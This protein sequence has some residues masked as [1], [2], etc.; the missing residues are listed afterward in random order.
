[1]MHS[2]VNALSGVKRVRGADVQQSGL[3]SYVSLEERVPAN[4]PLRGVRALLNE[5]LETMHR[6]FE[7]VYAEGGR[8]SIPPERLVR[9]LIL[10]V[11]YSIR[12][13]RLLCEQ[14]DYNLLFRWFVG[15]SVDE[16]IWDHSTFT[17]N[18]ERLI[19]AKVARKLLR[20]VIR[21]A[22]AARLL[23]NEHFS[24]DGTLIESWAAVKSMRRRD[25]RDEPR[26]PGR[27]P[28][29]DFHGEKRTNE[30]HVSPSDPEAKLYRKGKGQAAKLYYM[31]HVLMEHRHGLPVDVEVTEANGFAERE[32]ALAMLDRLSR[33][34][35]RTLAADKAYDVAEFLADCR[36]RGV[37]PHVA[38]N[39]GRAGGSALDAR[40]TRH[41]GYRWSQRI[42]KR[43]EEGFGWG[44]DGRPLRKMKH[45]GHTQVSFMATLTVGCYALLRVAKLI[46]PPTPAPA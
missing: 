7:R 23:S 43:I 26:G 16:P 22:R 35:R 20:R 18:R 38:C 6:D 31:G 10:Q 27:N 40:T 37:T 14:L 8:A 21:R 24:V 34:Q 1:M 41:A 28:T 13:E 19:E 15:L 4:H 42:R 39:D 36:A 11:L 17:K 5:A 30:T 3:F 25:G 46:V 32:A 44:K 12:S 2:S 33:R 29:V 9:A 45:T